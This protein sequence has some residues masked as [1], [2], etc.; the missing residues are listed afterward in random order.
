VKSSYSIPS[1]RPILVFP[2]V[3]PLAPISLPFGRCAGYTSKDPCDYL[4]CGVLLARIMTLSTYSVKWLYIYNRN[5]TAYIQIYTCFF[6]YVL[7]FKSFTASLSADPSL[8][9]AMSTPAVDIF[10]LSVAVRL[11]RQSS[12]GTMLFTKSVLFGDRVGSEFGRGISYMRILQST[13]RQRETQII[14]SNKITTSSS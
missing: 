8:T 11:R 10:S 12:R 14:V 13:L 1:P 4:A 6:N 9:L 2:T 7:V 3:T 5:T